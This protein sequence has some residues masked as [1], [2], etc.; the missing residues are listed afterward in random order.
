MAELKTRPTTASV[1]A[2]VDAVEHDQRRK[3]VR[4]VMKMMKEVT[5][6]RPKMWGPTIIG[7]GSY[8]YTYPSGREDQWMLT[9]VSPRKQN[10]TLYLMSGFDALEAPLKKLGKHKT[11]KS[12]LYIN[13]LDDVDPDVL[14]EL[15][16][17]SVEHM[18]A[19]YPTS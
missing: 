14:R 2:F 8:R 19:T 13:R 17:R 3:D 11:G 15:V 10:L 1:R 12:C 18:R 4:V 9:G 5:G 6:K 7:Y 16:R